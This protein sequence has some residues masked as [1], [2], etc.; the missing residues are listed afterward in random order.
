MISE[1]WNLIWLDIKSWLITTTLMFGPIILSN[2]IE[3]L[4][5]QDFGSHTEFVILALG[6]LLKLVQKWQSS[7]AYKV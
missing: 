3:L 2:F 5:K 7:T 4:M 6:G 1:K